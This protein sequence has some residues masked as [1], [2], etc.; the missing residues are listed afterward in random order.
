MPFPKTVSEAL[1]MSARWNAREAIQHWDSD[2]HNEALHSSVCL[3]IAAE[4]LLKHR[5]G[6]DEVPFGSNFFDHST[7][8]SV[9][10]VDMATSPSAKDS[11]CSPMSSGNLERQTRVIVG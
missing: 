2:D 9:G 7:V 10:H 3:G 6:A 5:P 8:H 4:L 11:W 1:L